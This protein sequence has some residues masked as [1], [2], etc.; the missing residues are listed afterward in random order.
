MS[1]M[2]EIIKRGE[3]SGRSYYCRPCNAMHSTL[4]PPSSDTCVA[5]FRQKDGGE[6]PAW[7]QRALRGVLPGKDLTN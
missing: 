1:L 3:E 5:L 7:M 6:Q 4:R 2:D